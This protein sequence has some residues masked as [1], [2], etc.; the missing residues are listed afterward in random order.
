M[1]KI[2]LTYISQAILNAYFWGKNTAEDVFK[3]E[4]IVLEEKT[5]EL[6]IEVLLFRQTVRETI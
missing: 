5:N 2:Y 3:T 4:V 6:T 1:K